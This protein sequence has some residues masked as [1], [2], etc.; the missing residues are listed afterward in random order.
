MRRDA[1]TP[2]VPELA[3]RLVRDAAAAELRLLDRERKAERR[4]AAAQKRLARDEAGLRRA[5]ERLRRSRDAVIE[6]E[7]A[8]RERQEQR[9]AGPASCQV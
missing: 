5:Q 1:P 3:R 8:L 6:A 9:A 2:D 7:L 4:L